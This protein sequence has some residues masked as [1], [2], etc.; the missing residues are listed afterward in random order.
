[1]NA[2]GCVEQL[3]EKAVKV[4]AAQETLTLK[5]T[6]PERDFS[7]TFYCGNAGLFCE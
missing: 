1:M 7:G 6:C 5:S 4:R 2:A 3:I